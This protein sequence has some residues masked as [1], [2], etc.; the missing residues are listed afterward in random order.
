[1]KYEEI[2]LE[3]IRFSAEDVITTSCTNETPEVGG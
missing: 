2:K 1:M 3:V